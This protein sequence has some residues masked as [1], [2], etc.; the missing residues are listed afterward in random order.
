M[1]IFFSVR[2]FGFVATGLLVAACG[3]QQTSHPPTSDPGTHDAVSCAQTLTAPPNGGVSSTTPGVTG[4][5][6]TYSCLAG[7]ALTGAATTTCEAS[8][9]WS[10]A[11]PSCTANSCG[12]VPA[13]V[14]NGTVTKPSPGSGV[15]GD[16]VTYGCNPGY[17]LSGSATSTCAAS[18]SWSEAP[19]CTPNSCATPP[20]APANGTVTTPT[21]TG[22]TG[23]TVT[24]TCNAGF[25][26]T[27]S[28]SASCQPSGTWSAAP[29]C[30]AQ[31][32]SPALSAPSGGT[33]S[34]TS[35]GT[36]DVRTYTCNAGHT[37]A[38]SAT[39]TCLADH[40]W[41]NAAP[42]CPAS[43]CGAVPASPANGAVTAPSPGAGVTG[44]TVSYT[45]NPG[46]TRTGSATA[47]CQASGS[48]SAAAVCAATSC[49]SP[50]S[51]PTNGTVTAPSPGAGVT[52]DSVTYGCNAGFTISGSP[53][54]T[55]QANDAGTSTWTAA[56][57]CNGDPCAPNLTTPTNGSVS[58]ITGVTGDTRTFACIPG[59]VL[60]GPATTICQANH[61][62]S[63]PV[64]TCSPIAPSAA[65]SQ[66]IA[67]GSPNPAAI[68]ETFSYALTVANTGNVRLDNMVVIENVPVEMS[69]VSVTTGAYS[70]L[71][72]F[73]TGVGVSLSYAK[74]TAPTVFTLW[75]SSPNTGTSSTL[76][77]PPGLA[78]GEYI[79]RLR[80]QYGAASPGMTATTFPRITGKIIAPDNAG[81]AVAVGHT[82]TAC[83]DLSA[84]FTAGPT[85]VTD[86]AN[87]VAF[88]VS[89]DT[90]PPVITCPADVSTQTDLTK[91]TATIA[92]STATATDNVSVAAITNTWSATGATVSGAFPAGVTDVTFT[93]KDPSN[94]PATCHFKVTVTTR[95]YCAG[96]PCAGMGAG[97]CTQTLGPAGVPIG[98]VCM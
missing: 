62:W 70:G 6:R 15:T 18:G 39:T 81:G 23:D 40:T 30:A 65:L 95:D 27:G 50:P 37:L 94:N 60:S 92:A 58:G 73:S 61:A 48:W 28:A 26:L 74:N 19:K 35:G 55:C 72:D 20:S 67:S 47:T 5:Q 22:M 4:E 46:Y 51:S 17:T 29:V 83:A 9:A 76:S 52:G 45:C 3:D 42:T 49:G 31:G 71:A 78:G 96:N 93:A 10:S 8:G 84:L 97:T 64:P 57:V 21:G 54:A 77:A 79:T 11:A 91:E 7:Y 43:S 80:W 13:A 85:N 59:D 82:V 89:A 16:T 38:G 32:C 63:N 68:N 86:N 66:S 98:K 36:G 2:S 56:P 75:G 69:V 25:T 24:Y 87:C 34:A 1:G 88:V 14:A 41:S 44:D 53:T 33:V 12:A 90:S